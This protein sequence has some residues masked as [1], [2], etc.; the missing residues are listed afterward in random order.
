[1]NLKMAENDNNS[2]DDDGG[3]ADDSNTHVLSTYWMPSCN[4]SI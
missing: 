4:A 1:M 2:E 3:A